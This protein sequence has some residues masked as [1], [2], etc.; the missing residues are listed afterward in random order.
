MQLTFFGVFWVGGG[1]YC[2]L[3]PERDQK[4]RFWKG[5]KCKFHPPRYFHSHRIYRVFPRKLVSRSHHG[6]WGGKCELHFL[7]PSLIW[8]CLGT[9]AN[10]FKMFEDV[11][12]TLKHHDLL[13]TCYNCIWT[14]PSCPS[15]IPRG[16][17]A[18]WPAKTLQKCKLHLGRF[19]L[20]KM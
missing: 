8:R 12:R 10:E 13:I 3:K 4:S 14:L 20:P 19:C 7:P 18:W 15:F 6:N 1:C 5:G 16:P 11:W 17:N 2:K 9:W